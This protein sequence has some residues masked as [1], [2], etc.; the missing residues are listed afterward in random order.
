MAKAETVDRKQDLTTLFEIKH[1]IE[2]GSTSIVCGDGGGSIT[3]IY[4]E[5]GD[6]NQKFEELRDIVVGIKKNNNVSSP[7]KNTVKREII[8]ILQKQKR[9]NSTQL[10]KMIG[11][12]RVRANE[13]LRELEDERIT[14]GVTVRK[15]KFYML[16]NDLIGKPYEE[17]A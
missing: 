11:L 2:K 12:S 17:K 6:L 13:Y 16:E 3:K 1:M 5:L 8:A 9:L 10:G 4:S 7:R 15:K 14:R